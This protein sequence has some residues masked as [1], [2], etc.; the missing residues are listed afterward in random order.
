ML[1]GRRSYLTNGL[2]VILLL[3]IVI[4]AWWGSLKLN[5]LPINRVKVESGYQ[6]ISRD[7]LK[8]A[9]LP[10]LRNSLLFI[11][12]DRVRQQLLQL[13]LIADVA[14]YRI[15]PD[16]V[17]I[18][19]TEQDIVARWGDNAVLNRDGEVLSSPGTAMLE[20]VPRLLG[21]AAQSQH[22]LQVY[23]ELSQ[24]LIPLQLMIDRLQLSDRQSWTLTLNN[25][26]KLILG[27]S[28]PS[29]G[30]ARFTAAYDEVFATTTA[31]AEQIDLRYPH[32]MA[33][34]WSDNVEKK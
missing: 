11:N 2:L 21:P 23:Q 8:S 24:L 3:L 19:V 4:G 33:V 31:I 12:I 22:V 6:Y 34:R 1:T 27:R 14:V 25:G 20:G 7:N 29:A 28:D 32:G 16:T 30:V 17:R 13:P 15:W 26:M 9:I 18:R 5:I 10:Y